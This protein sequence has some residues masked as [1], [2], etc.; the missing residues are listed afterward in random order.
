MNR[1]EEVAEK[2]GCTMAQVSLAWLMSKEGRANS[3]VLLVDAN[4]H[5]SGI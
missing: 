1:V 5:R 2:K 4:S 3:F